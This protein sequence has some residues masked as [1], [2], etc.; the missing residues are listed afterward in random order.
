[1]LL[2]R[3]LTL[4]DLKSTYLLF[5]FFLDGGLMPYKSV[6]ELP[7]QIK[8]LPPA[9]QR[10]WLRVFN[11]A[12]K[13]NSE[14]VAFKIA[15]SVVKQQYTKVGDNWIKRKSPARRSNA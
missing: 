6:K 3:L 1:M 11:T 8:V 10:I 5:E 12:I 7:P 9:A 15:W 4:T 14:E 2:S 13:T